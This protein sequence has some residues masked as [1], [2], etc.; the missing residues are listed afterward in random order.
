ML[1]LIIQSKELTRALSSTIGGTVGR[2]TLSSVLLTVDPLSPDA[3]LVARSLAR[4]SLHASAVLSVC[5]SAW[6]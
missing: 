6:R 4:L 1:K 2:G 3:Y 5:G